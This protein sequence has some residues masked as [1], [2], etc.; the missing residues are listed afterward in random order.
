MKRKVLK[1]EVSGEEEED[2]EKMKVESGRSGEVV[3]EEGQRG[4]W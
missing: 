2:E 3:G 4:N 1:M